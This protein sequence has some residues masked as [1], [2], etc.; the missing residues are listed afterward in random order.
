MCVILLSCTRL[1]D[2]RKK[3]PIYIGIL[4]LLLGIL[5]KELT[6]LKILPVVFILAGVVFKVYYGILRIRNKEYKPGYEI[7]ILLIGLLLFLFGIYLRT[8]GS[9]S[10]PLLFILPGI[11]LKVVFVVFF[12][13]KT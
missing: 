8:Q 10:D 9:G 6:T 11:I 13:R 5:L 3:W 12:I 7:G 1:Y 2:M 4:L